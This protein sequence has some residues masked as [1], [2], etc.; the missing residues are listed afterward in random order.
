MLTM[1]QI[2][3]DSLG[4]LISDVSRHLRRNFD[5]RARAIGAR[6]STDYVLLCP[7]DFSELDVRARYPASLA[8]G[9]L[10]VSYTHLTLPT[11]A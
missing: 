3:S 5:E 1:C 10:A 4:F 8:S 6:W 2:M 7:T 11:K 9:L